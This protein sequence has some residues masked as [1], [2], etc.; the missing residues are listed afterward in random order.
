MAR[1]VVLLERTS[2]QEM[3]PGAERDVNTIAAMHE[4]T[5]D[6]LQRTGFPGVT[7]RNAGRALLETITREMEP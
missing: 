2:P 4:F 5:P 3:L 6:Q 7:V 1:L